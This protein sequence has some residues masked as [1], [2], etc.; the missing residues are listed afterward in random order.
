MTAAG[1]LAFAAAMRVIDR[2][3]RDTAHRGLA[4]EPA[5]PPGLADH[6]ILVVGFRD[7]TDRRA[8]FVADHAHL[9]RG[10]ADEGIALLSTDEPNV[11]AGGAGDLASLAR[12]HL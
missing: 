1:G 8:A 12:L 6:D 4:A 9:A 2:V 3:H 10:H 5:V 7:R 11:D